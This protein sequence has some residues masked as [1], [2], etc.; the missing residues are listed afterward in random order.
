MLSNSELDSAVHCFA[1]VLVNMEQVW[2]SVGG[3]IPS[4]KEM[5][6]DMTTMDLLIIMAKNGIRFCKID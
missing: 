6:D 1:D 2:N 4:I 5:D 3:Y